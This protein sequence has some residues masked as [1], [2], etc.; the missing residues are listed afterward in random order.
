MLK[1]SYLPVIATLLFITIILVAQTLTPITYT[2]TH[3]TV[4]ELASQ[5]YRNKW[6]MQLGFISFGLLLSSA[7]L[8]TLTNHVRT[9]LTE[10]P[11]IVYALSIVMTGIWCTAPFIPDQPYDLTQARLHSVFATTAGIAF[12]VALIMHMLI[13]P[14]IKRKYLHLTC[15]VL[16]IS[17][18]A[19][20]GLATTH[21]GVIQRLL[22]ASSFLWL[23]FV[24]H[25][26]L[27][28]QHPR[29]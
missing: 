1:T 27:F 11:L 14:V 19:A 21:T 15:L 5:G 2:W 9:W 6:L 18:S 29:N 28:T 20:F 22:Y 7:A 10:L 25:S 26:P 13:D 17:T 3:N 23:I 12:S 16:V 8:T 24:Y 4:S